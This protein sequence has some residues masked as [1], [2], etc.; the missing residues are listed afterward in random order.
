MLLSYLACELSNVGAIPLGRT[1]EHNATRV[2]I[3]A[4]EW[5]EEY[6]NGAL[7][8]LVRNPDG[9]V[10]PAEVTTDSYVLTWI[11][12]KDETAI[13]GNGEIELILSADGY[14]VKSARC[15]TQI[16]AALTQ[17]T[18]SLPESTPEWVSQLIAA[19]PEVSAIPEVT[20]EAK[21]AT[22]QAQTA[23]KQIGNLTASA[24]DS[25][26]VGVTV[27]KSTDKYHFEFKLRR[28]ATGPVGPTGATGAT[29][30]TGPQGPKGDPFTYEDFTAEQLTKLTGPVGA[31]GAKGDKGDPFTYED[32]TEDQLAALTGPQ[33]PKGDPGLCAFHIDDNGHLIMTYPDD[34]DTPDFH[35]DASGHLIYTF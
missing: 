6:P 23:A 27:T 10:Y 3:D 7:A 33:G 32:F 28:G 4:T 9:A 1:G 17:N 22:E 15:A 20:K 13:A 2:I 25:D 14:I 18:D 5:Q 35:I 19:L 30:A 31:T 34:G 12:T 29:G 24:V 21:T 16:D 11:V 26:T 8:L